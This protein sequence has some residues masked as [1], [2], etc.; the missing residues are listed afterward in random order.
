[1]TTNQENRN[2]H[3]VLEGVTLTEPFSARGM[4][5]RSEIPIRGRQ[6]HSR[7]LL[8]QL[9][10]LE[11]VAETAATI[12][13]H[14]GMEEGLGL[15]VEFESFPG[16]ELAFESLARENTGIELFN[17]RDGANDDKPGVIQATVFV[18][19]G[20]LSHFENLIR[21]YVDEKVDVRGRPRDNRRL[22]DAIDQ[23]RAASLRALWTDTSDFPSNTEEPLWWEVWLPV[24]R[25]RQE[26]ISGFLTRVEAIGSGA[27]ALSQP[28]AGAGSST[29][30]AGM[31]R[32][33]DA[34]C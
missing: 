18:P 26:I 13:R 17:V 30:D 29:G 33:G 23:I 32:R 8:G 3:F 21:D 14:A 34:G 15:R 6:E 27:P 28:D 16:I 31:R 22:L 12:Q 4:G 19:D 25:N 10:D 20:K 1:M 5:P 2:P 11:S 9:S 24:R 7:R